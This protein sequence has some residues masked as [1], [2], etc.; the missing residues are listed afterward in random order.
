MKLNERYDGSDNPFEGDRTLIL[1]SLPVNARVTKAGVLLTPAQNAAGELFEENITFTGSPDNLGATKITGTGFVE[2]D[3]HARR[4]LV[5]VI[6]KNII[7]LAGNTTPTPLAN[8]QV[9]LGGGVYVEINNKGALRSPDDD[10]FS[11]KNDGKLPGLKVNKFKFSQI[12]PNTN[13]VDITQVTISSV[14]TNVSVR[15]GNL[16]PFWTH[17]GELTGEDV[18][19]DFAAI[20]Q[21][22]LSEAKTENGFY[23]LPLILHSDT[24]AR[25][26]VTL[27][28]EYQIETSVMP[29]G[30]NEVQLPYDFGTLP[31]AQ[32]NVLQIAVPPN[33]RVA[34]K[35]VS[36]RVRGAFEETR[37]VYGATG[38]V[39]PAGTVDISPGLS[40]A[41]LI[42]L[43]ETLKA[44]AI[45]SF[46]GRE[47]SRKTAIGFA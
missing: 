5:S 12:S 35:G 32:E 22:F 2:V 4:T 37:I 23:N 7:E 44:T 9:D 34:P 42:S 43:P 1:R 46:Y 31:K 36:A 30:L 47:T 6:G 27:T 38:A 13:P 26:T 41:Q 25:L 24:I 40:Q 18:S 10:L 17:L 19:P 33:M 16:P 3:F 28:I 21:V 8:L 45:R 15:L 11:L 29:Q 14:P 39:T 20:L